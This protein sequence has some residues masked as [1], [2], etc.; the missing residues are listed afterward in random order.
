[1]SARWCKG[2]IKILGNR[3]EIEVYLRVLTCDKAGKE[4]SQV[5]IFVACTVAEHI[6]RRRLRGSAACH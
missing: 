2:S 6:S 4:K 1:M 5:C 3:L